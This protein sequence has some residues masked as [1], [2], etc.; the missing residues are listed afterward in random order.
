MIQNTDGRRASDIL[1]DE[2]S[3]SRNSVRRENI[4]II[5]QVCDQMEKDRVAINAAEVARRGGENG[6]AYS[7]ISNKGSMLGEYIKQR[8]AE[9]A[10][11]LPPAKPSG[12]N[13]ADNIS[14]P[15]LAAQV[16]DKECTARWFQKENTAL[17]HLF[18]S[19]SPGVDID[20]ALTRATKGQ[21]FALASPQPAAPA[22][23]NAELGGALLRLMDHLIRERQYVEMRGRLTIN[24]KVVLDPRELQVYRQACGLSDAEWQQRYNIVDTGGL[25]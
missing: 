19:M 5:K 18:K 24:H 3:A 21:P 4:R 6:P 22:I 25:L 23:G 8:I 2:I 16:R 20:A 17:R 15:V 14:D 11:T 7:T 12:H 1:Y 10:S 13:L 9:Q